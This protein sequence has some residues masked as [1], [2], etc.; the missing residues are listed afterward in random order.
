MKHSDRCDLVSF[1]IER[2]FVSLDPHSHLIDGRVMV[3]VL[4]GTNKRSH[5][6]EIVQTDHRALCAD[7]HKVT[8]GMNGEGSDFGGFFG[9][10]NRLFVVAVQLIDAEKVLI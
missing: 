1:H 2:G 6:I 9:C 7:E 5:A 10:V 4:E 8:G 3:F